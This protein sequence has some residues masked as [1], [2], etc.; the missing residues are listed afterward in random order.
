MLKSDGVGKRRIMEFL[1]I[2]RQLIFHE[3]LGL[4]P[5]ITF[6]ESTTIQELGLS[7]KGDSSELLQALIEKAKEVLDRHVTLL[8]EMMTA[9]R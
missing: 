8:G 5:L 2:M 7:P 4:K 6:G 1:Q 9:D 3:K